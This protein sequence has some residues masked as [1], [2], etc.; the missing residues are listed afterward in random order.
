MPRTSQWSTGSTTT[1]SPSRAFCTSL[2]VSTT[3]PT[4]SC[5]NVNG[6]E[7]SGAK[8]GLCLAVRAPRSLPQM[9]QSKGLIRAQREFGEFWS[10]T[11]ATGSGRTR[12]CRVWESRSRRP[13]KQPGRNT[14]YAL[15][16][17][18]DCYLLLKWQVLEHVSRGG[19]ERTKGVRDAD[20]CQPSRQ[21]LPAT[22]AT[23]R[24]IHAEQFVP[25]GRLKQ[26]HGHFFQLLHVSQGIEGGHILQMAPRTGSAL[27]TAGFSGLRWL[28]LPL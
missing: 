27:A 22:T 16:S 11:S 4:T 15:D 19:S 12:W 8:N 13:E 5:P 23:A 14:F 28:H 7:V 9:P 1:R 17:Q 24:T 21:S 20:P 18:Q 10:S 25:T 6:N 2:P 26:A 3:V